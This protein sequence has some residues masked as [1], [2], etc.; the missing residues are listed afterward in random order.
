[1]RFACWTSKAYR[2]TLRICN[3]LI[4]H[5]SPRTRLTVYVTRTLPVLFSLLLSYK[6]VASAQQNSSLLSHL[7]M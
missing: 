4:L 1:M 6:V 7:L 2:H 5:G 3:T